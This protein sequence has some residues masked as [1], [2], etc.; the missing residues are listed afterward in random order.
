MRMYFLKR[1]E[2]FEKHLKNSN[3]DKPLL[4]EL[5]SKIKSI[6]ENPEKGKELTKSLAGYKSV[7]V[8]GKYRLVF[9]VDDKLQEI[10]LIAFGHRKEIYDL[11]AMILR[12]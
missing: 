12:K 3:K 11:V 2:T 4:E 5:F 7:R 6:Q 1:T 10:T 8:K 9:K